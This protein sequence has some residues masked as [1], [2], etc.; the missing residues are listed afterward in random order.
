LVRSIAS[1]AGT[2]VGV[3]GLVLI[4]SGAAAGCRHPPIMDFSRLVDAR[5]LASDLLVQFTKSVDAGNRAVMADTDE[6]STAFAHEAQQA[7]EAV[8]KDIDSLAKILRE[9]EYSTESEMLAEFTTR[10]DEYRKLD[11]SILELAVENTNLKAQRLS[12]GPAQEAA[13]AFR[14]ALQSA[15]A[16]APPKNALRVQALVAEA[17]A[18]VREMQVLQAPHIAESDE[19]AMTRLEQKAKEAEGLARRGLDALAPLVP[20]IA[21]AQLDGSRAALDKFVDLNGQIVALSRRNS[22]V[23]SLA[24]SLGQKRMLT[25]TCEDSLGALQDALAKRGFTGTR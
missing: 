25:A 17:V 19:A 16:K 14:D 24:L 7:S 20:P 21:K 15:A 11:Q 6:A 13:D 22:N 18:A 23:R 1:I 2:S 4:A 8:S 12:F 10:F 3:C 5:Q 9:L